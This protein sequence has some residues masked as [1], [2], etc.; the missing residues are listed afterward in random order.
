MNQKKVK[1]LRRWA[2]GMAAGHPAVAY[3]PIGQPRIPKFDE[4]KNLVGFYKGESRILAPSLKLATKLAKK[5]SR[6]NIS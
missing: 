6:A 1:A 3:D 5:H 2:R 4:D